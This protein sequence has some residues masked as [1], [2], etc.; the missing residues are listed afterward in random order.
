MHRIASHRISDC[1]LSCWQHSISSVVAWY[2]ISDRKSESNEWTNKRCND[3]IPLHYR[4]HVGMLASSKRGRIRLF[5]YTCIDTFVHII[6]LAWHC[7]SFFARATRQ[8]HMWPTTQNIR[9]YVYIVHR[10]L[11]CHHCCWF[12]LRFTF[13]LGICCVFK[14]KYQLT[15][16]RHY[17]RQITRHFN[18]T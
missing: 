16:C 5:I 9:T 13:S 17:C 1:L 6:C 2:W 18:C 3:L 12:G 15:K 8:H 11:C 4:L 10:V 14:V 7:V